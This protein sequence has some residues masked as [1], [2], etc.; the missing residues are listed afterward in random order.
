MNPLRAKMADHEEV[1]RRI[2][3]I[4]GISYPVLTPNIQGFEKY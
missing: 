4:A 1:F 3:K 2:N